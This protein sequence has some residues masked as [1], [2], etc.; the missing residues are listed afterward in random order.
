MACHGRKTLAKDY[1]RAVLV[2]GSVPLYRHCR[3]GIG[4]FRKGDKII[5]SEY[6]YK[7]AN[8]EKYY[9]IILYIIKKN[10]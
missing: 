2:D 9:K 3:E 4:F 6:M 1:F 10:L 7:I 8:I 5:P